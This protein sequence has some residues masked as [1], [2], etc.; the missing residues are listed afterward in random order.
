M[1]HYL[2]NRFKNVL[3]EIIYDKGQ[4]T[5]KK[6]SF[7]AKVYTVWT[8]EMATVIRMRF[9][10][11]HYFDYEV[12]RESQWRHYDLF[13]ETPRINLIFWILC[14]ILSKFHV[15]ETYIKLIVS[16]YEYNRKK[17][18]YTSCTAS[19]ELFLLCSVLNI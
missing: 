12:I 11:Y 2:Y 1:C 9:F 13:N 8:L 10:W 7:L 18:I 17:I 5:C 16:L 6:L 19:L 3:C 15:T 4:C 14:K